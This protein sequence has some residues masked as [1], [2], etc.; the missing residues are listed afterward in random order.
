MKKGFEVDDVL[1]TDGLDASTG[2]SSVSNPDPYILSE[3][4]AKSSK[5]TIPYIPERGKRSAN[6]GA[7]YDR[8]YCMPVAPGKM[9]TG[10]PENKNVLYLSAE[11]IYDATALSTWMSRFPDI[12]IFVL[13][14]TI[15]PE[16][17]KDDGSFNRFSINPRLSYYD[18]GDINNSKVCDNF[19]LVGPADAIET[20]LSKIYLYACK[21]ITELFLI[22][23][24]RLPVLNSDNTRFN[25][26]ISKEDTLGQYV[27]SAKNIVVEV[28]QVPGHRKIYLNCEGIQT[29]VL[30]IICSE[31]H[32]EPCKLDVNVKSPVNVDLYLGGGPSLDVPEYG[33]Y[34]HDFKLCWDV[35]T[36]YTPEV[37]IPYLWRRNV[38][39]NRYPY[40][41]LHGDLC[42]F[43]FIDN[44]GKKTRKVK[45]DHNFAPN[46]RKYGRCSVYYWE[47]TVDHVRQFRRQVTRNNRYMEFIPQT[48]RNNGSVS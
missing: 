9:Y 27:V 32:D 15:G 37:E 35:K 18:S 45:I 13:P 17:I 8:E 30:Q 19:G 26:W 40:V 14:V 10:A 39:T 11:R 44:S 34:I 24:D 31:L 47:K 3:L 43:C 23:T 22:P 4:I 46:Q 21:E 16:D 42:G 28:S 5:W 38:P 36:E 6:A 25:M 2:Y 12:K 29:D 41:T 33:H 1:T 7:V 48:H 20:V